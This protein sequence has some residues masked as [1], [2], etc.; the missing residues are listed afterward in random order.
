MDRKRAKD[1]LPRF[2][3]AATA[4][5]VAPG[6]VHARVAEVATQ[7]MVFGVGDF[8]E[9]LKERYLELR[10]LFLS[11]SVPKHAV[12]HPDHRKQVAAYYLSPRKAR[13]AADLI[14]EILEAIVWMCCH[15]ESQL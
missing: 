10:G 14:N 12:G 2:L 9:E 6:P 5:A 1:L 8:P 4:M 3:N 13:R 7:V 11:R 15:E